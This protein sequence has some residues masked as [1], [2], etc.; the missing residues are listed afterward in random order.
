[1]LVIAE[2]PKQPVPFYVAN[3]PI[4]D[5]GFAGN[6]FGF[7]F[8]HSPNVLRLELPFWFTLLGVVATATAPWWRLRFSVRTLIIATTLVAVVLGLVV[9]AAR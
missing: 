2:R 6:I 3:T 8:E 4:E 1:M 9:Y 5:A 7:Y